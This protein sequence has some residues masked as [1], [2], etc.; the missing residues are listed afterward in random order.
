MYLLQAFKNNEY[1]I[2]LAQFNKKFSIFYM[3][4]PILN[5]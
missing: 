5:K 4:T 2:S 1:H 3:C